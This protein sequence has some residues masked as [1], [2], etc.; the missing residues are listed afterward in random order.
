MQAQVSLQCEP[1]WHFNA[2]SARSNQVCIQIKMTDRDIKAQWHFKNLWYLCILCIYAFVDLNFNLWGISVSECWLSSVGMRCHHVLTSMIK[3]NATVCNMKRWL[4][5]PL[6][7]LFKEIKDKN[8]VY[9]HRFVAIKVS[10]YAFCFLVSTNW[11]LKFLCANNS[12]SAQAALTSGACSE[13]ISWL[14]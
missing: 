2:L 6:A 9:R 8:R 13:V 11:F 1:P 7:H 4:L 10:V 14:I 3:G 12:Q 5:S